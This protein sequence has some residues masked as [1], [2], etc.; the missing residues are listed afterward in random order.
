MDGWSSLFCGLKAINTANHTNCL[1][2]ILLHCNFLCAHVVS[3][4]SLAK[5]YCLLYDSLTVQSNLFFRGLTPA[6]A[7]YNFLMKAKDLDYYGIELFQAQVIEIH[8]Y[9][10]CDIM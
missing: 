10:S 2:F 5:L 7:E 4:C 6:D 8:K 9:R 1:R 3:I